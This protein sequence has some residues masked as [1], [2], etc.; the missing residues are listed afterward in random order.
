[1][2]LQRRNKYQLCENYPTEQT[3]RFYKSLKKELKHNRTY[4][5]N[6][7]IAYKVVCDSLKA[8]K[9]NFLKERQKDRFEELFAS[10][11]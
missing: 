7:K 11:E 9:Q 6:C 10:V 5:G 8:E 2:E 4:Y 3:Y 1:M